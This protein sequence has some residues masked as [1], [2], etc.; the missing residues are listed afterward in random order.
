M[1]SET[2][3]L[4]PSPATSFA[5]K[6]CLKPSSR[7]LRTPS[8][9]CDSPQIA[10]SE[11]LR[12]LALQ[13]IPQ[14]NSTVIIEPAKA[15]LDHSLFC[16]PQP[17]R[18]DS[19]M[20][21]VE[22]KPNKTAA[23]F[24][25]SPTSTPPRVRPDTTSPDQDT[26]PKS[27]PRMT[28]PRSLRPG[29]PPTRRSSNATRR[30]PPPLPERSLSDQSIQSIF[31]VYDHSLP[32][33]QQHY[34]PAQDAPSTPPKP[35]SRRRSLS[36]PRPAL[37]LATAATIASKEPQIA[38]LPDLQ[39]LWAAASGTSPQN[40]RVRK[41]RLAMHREMPSSS[42][43][44]NTPLEI[45][46]SKFYTFVRRSSTPSKPED[47]AAEMLVRRH[48]PLKDITL[49][50]A[51]I[52]IAQPQT[53][54]DSHEPIAT[55]IFPQTAALTALENAAISPR[56]ISIANFDPNAASP[57]A[58]QLA[59]DAV[60]E[61]KQKEQCKIVCTPEKNQFG[62]PENKYQ[63]QHPRLGQFGVTVKGQ[64]NLLGK[65]EPPNRFNRVSSYE[66]IS[67]HHPYANVNKATRLAP[68]VASLDITA[69]VLEI[70]VA[71]L[72]GVDSAYIIDTAVCALMTVA[73]MESE[74]SERDMK[75]KPSSFD[76]PPS[77]APNKSGT[78]GSATSSHKSSRIMQWRNSFEK[79]Q[80]KDKPL[81]P[82]PPPALK[83]EAKLPIV[84]RGVLKLLGFSFQAII[85]LLG[86]GVKV[87]T[88]LLLSIGKAGSKV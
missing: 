55:T 2:F 48:H 50:I 16:E 44:H 76:A 45:G 23:D 5:P 32:L 82:P 14:R 62:A 20:D 22:S 63:L 85:W 69:G 75:P 43:S 80:G 70:D 7:T 31:P 30:S 36:V 11:V 1:P 79:G 71:A 8:P 26:S 81:P 27:P 25:K 60:V 87:L 84:L 41:V 73:L 9:V 19:P 37:K 72:K 88:R 56:A 13:V 10:K 4:F 67:L 59:F 65:A 77:E 21:E 78:W 42:S 39:A 40:N 49:P 35:S 61:A 74:S 52:E 15:H 83:A 24:R 17:P 46:F 51:Q 29:S 68:E 86:L 58:A 54:E 34:Y 57:Q 18:S 12:G 64:I 47:A 38:S 28:S 3:S 6:S 33:S 53:E 66:K